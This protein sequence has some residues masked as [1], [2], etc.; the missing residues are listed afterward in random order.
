MTT[1]SKPIIVS[2]S[3]DSNIVGDGITNSN[4]LTLNGTAAANS[5]VTVYD[6]TTLLGTVTADGTGAWSYLTPTLA[7][8]TNSFTATDA[9]AGNTSPSSDALNVT[10]DTQAPNA[11]YPQTTA[12]GEIA[13]VSPI[14]GYIFG[15]AT[16]NYVWGYHF[17]SD[18]N[19][20]TLTGT[21]EAYSTIKIFDGTTL[22]GTTTT[23]PWGSWSY[24][25]GPLTSGNHSLTETA[26]D[27]AGNS[28]QA[29]SVLSISVQSDV[30]LTSNTASYSNV[31]WTY[32]AATNPWNVG[33]LVNG[34]DYW[35][36]ITLSPASFPNGV[37]VSWSFPMT[38][39]GSWYVRAYP[40]VKFI[41]HDVS[42]N[43]IFT[44]V[45]NFVDLNSSYNVNIGGDT[46]DFNIAYDI[47]LYDKPNGNVLDELMVWVHQPTARLGINEPNNVTVPG[48]TNASLEFVPSATGWTFIGLGSPTDA[49]SGTISIS[50]IFKTLIWNGM[51]TGQEYVGDIQFGAEVTA[52]AGQFHLNNFSNDWNANSPL[53]GTTGNDTIPISNSGGNNVVGG[54]GTDTVVYSDL[55]SDYQIKTVGSEV[56]VTKGTDISTLDELQGV[57]FIKFSNGTYD[58]VTGTFAGSAGTIPAPSINTFSPDSRTVGDGI[59]NATTLTLT[60]TAAAN[61]TVAVLDGTGQLGTTTA[62]ISGAWSFVASQLTDGTHSFTA[63]ATDA[64]GNTS[65]ASA[66]ISVTVDTVA[67]NSPVI[68]SDAVVNTNEI[69]LTGTAE[70]NSTVNVF[71]GTT[72][73]GTVTANASGGWSFTTGPLSSGAHAFTA[74][75]TDAAGN[76]SALSQAIDP[77]ISVL[78]PSIVAFSPDTGT[79]GDGVTNANQLTLTGTAV[80]N[81]TVN[82][83]DGTTLLGTT[84]SNSSGAWTIKT[85]TLVNGSHSFTATDTVSGTTSAASAALAVIV[86][87]VAPAVKESIAHDTGSSSTDKITSN[88]MLTGS[89]DPNAVVH[90]TVDGKA[91]AGTAT[92]DAS[93]TWTFTPTSL[94]DGSHTIVASEADAAGNTGTASLAFKL[95]TTA[96]VVM[97][98]L[99]KDTGASSTDK[100]TTNDTVTGSSDPNAVVHFTVDGSLIAATATSN[101]NGIWTFTPTGLASGSHTIVASE[102]DAAGNTGTATIA[103]TLDQKAP[104]TSIADIIQQ[105]VN[106][107]ST[108]TLSGSSS[109]AGSLVTLYDGKTAVGT[110]TVNSTGDWSISLTNLSNTVHK[111]TAAATD[112]AGNKGASSQVAILG[113]TGSDKIAGV[114]GGDTIV[115]NG[116]ADNFTAASGNDTFIFNPGFGKDTV[117]KFDLNHDVLTFDHSLFASVAEILSHTQDVHGNAVVTFDSADTVTLVG[118]TT[119]QLTG[120]QNDFHII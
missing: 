108:T 60:G 4:R 10:V 56:L 91:I 93:G 8:G 103:F 23:N 57:R 59:T 101:S 20:L 99:A 2:F 118:I 116:G 32:I 3:P 15:S 104:V 18:A 75:A 90:F 6:G 88:D 115:G 76:T 94:A 21:A 26:T 50:D 39:S 80:A 37:D 51:L 24:T 34:I 82:I 72:L 73:L 54:G 95:D 92:A 33:D 43:Q 65:Q 46:G 38:N 117:S 45:G 83:Y 63:V 107:V 105:T 12:P 49:L 87:T 112:T 110:T 9:V 22:L 81:S 86:D 120:H 61:S 13:P 113:T 68:T 89:G 5:L 111:F 84:T 100:I 52:G 17:V 29:T 44:Q 78:P 30:T 114:A 66:A 36:N 7:D 69:L 77:I 71:E 85:T 58:V 96:P 109:E 16:A 48:L 55:Y 53:F 62:N 74:T 28:S 67:P 40:E 79:V 25:T 64:A 42:G 35:E 1:V 98:S 19:S 47:F 70:A 102:T 27:A 41:P 119:A 11:P 31:A 97:E 14:I 106:N